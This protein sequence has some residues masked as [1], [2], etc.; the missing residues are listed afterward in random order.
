MNTVSKKSMLFAVTVGLVSLT[1]CVGGGGG[2]S[3]STPLAPRPTITASE[4]TG[5]MPELSYLAENY[6]NTGDSGGLKASLTNGGKLVSDTPI[7]YH[8]SNNPQ[9]DPDLDP[10]L[11]I[12]EGSSSIVITAEYGPEND[13]GTGTIEFK[14]GDNGDFKVYG[15]L[16]P[17][18]INPPKSLLA[19][20]IKD[21]DDTARKLAGLPQAGTAVTNEDLGD[22]IFFSGTYPVGGKQFLVLN[23]GLVDLEYASFGG[24]GAEYI[25]DGTLAWRDESRTGIYYEIDYRPLSGG[26]PAALKAPA[27]NA[28][29]TGKTVALATQFNGNTLQSPDQKFFHGD[30]SLKIA[31]TGQ[32]GNLAMNFPNF[33]DIGFKFNVSGSTFTAD[34]TTLTVTDNGNT[35]KFR[36]PT[37]IDT[38]NDGYLNASL[39]GNFYGDPNGSSAS[40]AVGRFGIWAKD[41]AHD[42]EFSIVGSFG[43]KQ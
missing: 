9:S 19:V 36:F 1:A 35:T 23:S 28:A 38:S 3:G 40:E 15:E 8:D 12:T 20:G 43:V 30:A 6:A 7:P 22:D 29:F 18:G 37:N 13:R 27:A 2:G 10:Y 34:K 24:W 17:D 25:M 21:L 5:G 33:Y 16:D 11:E 39:N 31:P 4:I 26:D 41:T 42:D 14:T 32:S